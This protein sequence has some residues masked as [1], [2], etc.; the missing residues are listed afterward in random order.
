MR[1]KERERERE[2]EEGRGGEDE[3]R[4][5]IRTWADTRCS[6]IRVSQGMVAQQSSDV[7]GLKLRQHHLAPGGA[8]SSRRTQK[9]H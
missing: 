4:G 9:E 8:G 5:C 2:R 1:K 7:K 6:G 3:K